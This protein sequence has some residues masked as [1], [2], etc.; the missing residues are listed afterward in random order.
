MNKK[1]IARAYY[2]IY[3]QNHRQ[4]Q[5][6]KA[7]QWYLANEENRMKHNNATLKYL[8]KNKKKIYE[9]RKIKYLFSILMKELLNKCH[10]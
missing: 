6:D 1:E 4:E 3:Y 2:K 8:N 10:N 5:I 9:R 7:T